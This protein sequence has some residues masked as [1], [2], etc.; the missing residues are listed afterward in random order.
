MVEKKIAVQK[1]EQKELVLP[2]ERVEFKKLLALNPNYFGNL[3]GSS[4]KPVK[5]IIGNTTYE[6]VSCLGFNPALNLLEATVLIKLPSGY[7]GTLCTPGSTEYVRFYIDYG[8]GWVDAGL[9][10]FNAH[11]IS[12]TLDCAKKLDK[13]LAYVVTL[14]LDP[15][16]DICKRPV[17]PKVRAILS[18]QTMPPAGL[19]DWPPI[20]GNVLDQHIQIKPRF[21]FFSDLFEFLPKEALKK[22]PH[23]I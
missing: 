12:N 1:G 6:K 4:F 17:L 15:H 5:E 9:S 18:W 23:M 3:K 8:S 10:S 2:K 11:D 16:R 22:I 7:N 21:P 20:W 13:P 19:P 14:S